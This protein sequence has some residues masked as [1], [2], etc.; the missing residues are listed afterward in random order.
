MKP[1]YLSVDL[2]GTHLRIAVLD[3]SGK[4]RELQKLSSEKVRR[5]EDLV[6]RLIEGIEKFAQQFASPGLCGVALGV[7]G[8]VQGDQGIIFQSPHFPEWKDFALVSALA[9]KISLPIFLENDA[10]KAALGEAYLGAGKNFKDFVMLTL[11]TG[12]GSGII[13]DRKI[14]HGSS[15]LAGEV[16]HIV[17]E[18]H[19]LPGALGIRGTLETFASLSGLR[20]QLENFLGRSFADTANDPISS[21]DLKSPTLPEELARLA[22]EG[23]AIARDLWQDFGQALACGLACL[24]HVLGIFNFVIGGGLA[25]AWDHFYPAMMEELPERMYRS[26]FPWVKIERAQ[27]GA[28][29]GL[30]GGIPMIQQ[31]LHKE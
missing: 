31:G 3:D 4:I 27:L 15:G 9:K 12:I 5:P 2:G 10:N 8:L 28:E 25:G 29:A 22:Q 18:R 14:F 24:T 21:L 6:A 20:L 30:L 7:P 11:G 1:L 13:V 17:I 26:T 23:N 19:G 16:G